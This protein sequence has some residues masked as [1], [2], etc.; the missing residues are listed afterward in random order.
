MAWFDIGGGDSVW[1][2]TTQEIEAEKRRKEEPQEQKQQDI[3]D[4]TLI[5]TETAVENAIEEETDKE[6]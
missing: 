5:E 2:Q 6:Q 4:G 1:I 3:E